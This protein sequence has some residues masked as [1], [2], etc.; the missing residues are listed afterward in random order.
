MSQVEWCKHQALPETRQ[1]MDAAFEMLCKPVKLNRAFE[2]LK[3]SDVE[4][5]VGRLVI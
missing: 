5:T 1:K 2:G 4:R 3:D